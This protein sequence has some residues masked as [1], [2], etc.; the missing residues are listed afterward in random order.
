MA[1]EPRQILLV[2]IKLG[3]KERRSFETIGNPRPALQQPARPGEADKANAYFYSAGPMDAGE[4][5]IGLAPGLD[6]AAGQLCKFLPTGHE[7]GTGERGCMLQARWLKQKFVISHDPW[8]A[9]IDVESIVAHR[10]K[11]RAV[12]VH[13]P[14]ALV[15]RQLRLTTEQRQTARQQA[16]SERQYRLMRWPAAQ[17]FLI[18]RDFAEVR[19]QLRHSGNRPCLEAAPD[20]LEQL[21]ANP[22]C[23]L[24]R[25]HAAH[26]LQV[27]AKPR[28]PGYGQINPAR[29][30]RAAWECQVSMKKTSPRPQA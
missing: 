4:E 15:F 22:G 24:A 23:D 30:S 13:K 5:W 27:P 18:Y 7:P 28:A 3:A 25:A 17:A 26:P 6:L 9:R 11:A 8:I 1:A 29:R 20:R 10:G 14:V 19:S 2:T 12:G 16:L 21:V